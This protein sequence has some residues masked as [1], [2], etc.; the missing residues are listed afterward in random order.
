MVKPNFVVIYADD[1]GYGDLGCYGSDVIQTPHLD[2][3]AAQG[4][5]FTQWYSN[6]P[7]CS[8]SR[9]A[10]LTGRYP[11]RTGITS[12]LG[13]RRTTPGLPARE[14]TVAKHLQTLGYT[15][16][17]MG[18]WHLGVAPASRPNAHGFTEFFGFLAGAVD[19][20]SHIYYY[21]LP[22]GIDPIHDLWHNE[23]EV[24]WNGQ[25]LTELLT[26]RAVQFIEHHAGQPFFLYLPYNAPHWPMHAPKSYLERF[27]ELPAERRIMAAMIA[28]MDD[29]V[30]AVLDALART[31]CAEDTLVFFSS[32][33]GPS[34]EARNF[35]DGQEDPYYGGSAGIFQGY[36]YSLF[37]GGIREPAILRYPA[38]VSAGQVCEQVGMMVDLYPTLI[39]LAGGTPPQD[40]L[41]DGYDI[42]PMVTEGASIPPRQI[43][44]EYAGQLAVRQGNWKLILNGRLDGERL[45]PDVVHLSDLDHDPAERMNL[46]DQYPQLVAQLKRDVEAWYQGCLLHT[47]QE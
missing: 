45:A 4:A 1:L 31:G 19:Y 12:I 24:W 41:L 9:A 28:A 15:T 6:C 26:E 35:L 2:Q 40:R 33:N 21:G 14:V 22:G 32:D 20:Y 34:A 27:R 44:W 23:Q 30:G 38:R 17:I 7:V 18:K 47:A 11:V 16:G 29:G 42:L 13:G 46:K 5:R 10:L 8:P 25:Y 39:H 43:F 37:E 36:K 3:L